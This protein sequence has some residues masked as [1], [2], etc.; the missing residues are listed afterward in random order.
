MR[1]GMI[2]ILILALALSAKGVSFNDFYH[3]WA[4]EVHSPLTEISTFLPSDTG[5]VHYFWTHAN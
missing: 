5:P 4:R 1:T 3:T 2:V